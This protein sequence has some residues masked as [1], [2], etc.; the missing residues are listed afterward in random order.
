MV[1]ELTCLI[2]SQ[3][4]MRTVFKVCTYAGTYR[5]GSVYKFEVSSNEGS[6]LGGAGCFTTQEGDDFDL[7]Y[8]GF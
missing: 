4:P 7:D 2:F 1:D 3:Y 6:Q 5:F 8:T